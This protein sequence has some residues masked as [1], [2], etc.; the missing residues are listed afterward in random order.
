LFNG[1]EGKIAIF[2]TKQNDY[3]ENSDDELENLIV[4]SNI[5]AKKSITGNI[6]YSCFKNFRYKNKG[7]GLLICYNDDK[8][9]DIAV[10]YSQELAEKCPIYAQKETIKGKFMSSKVI[11]PP[12]ED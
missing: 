7:F 5:Y 10:K 9:L 11:P 4:Y 12:D 8:L 2:V 3:Y 6:E 1:Q